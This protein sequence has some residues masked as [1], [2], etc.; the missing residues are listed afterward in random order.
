MK[1]KT[2]EVEGKTYAQLD[3]E[4]RVLYDNN[5]EEYA[6]DAGKTYSKI[7]EL[8]NEA[9]T[10]REAKEAAEAKA[11]EASKKLDGVDL[12]KMVDAGKLDEVKAEVEQRYEQ[13]LAEEAK[14]RQRLEQ[15]YNSEKLAS[16][17][18]SSKFVN[19]SLAVPPDMAQ[20]T[21]GNRFKVEGGK[22]VATDDSG[23]TIYSRKNP[24]SPA[25]FDEAMG[26]IVESYPHR[27]RIMKPSGAKGV[28]S[29]PEGEGAP[30][31]ISRGDFSNLHPSKQSELARQAQEGKVKIVD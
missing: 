17:F 3:S 9:K 14:K 8:T 16:A 25:D 1:L 20:S 6:F 21:F 11:A 24:G 26:L 28:G 15:Q 31:T 7:Q 30:R 27:D 23:N 18:A 29:D 19:D 22:I 5:G 2:V 4:G 10:H 13:R 12:S